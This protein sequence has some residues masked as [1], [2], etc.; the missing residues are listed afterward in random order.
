MFLSIEV[1]SMQIFENASLAAQTWTGKET[2]QDAAE[3]L[4]AYEFFKFF[5]HAIAAQLA[6][7]SHDATVATGP[8]TPSPEG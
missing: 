4:P 2:R 1:E 5:L 8:E 7:R 3:I 6:D